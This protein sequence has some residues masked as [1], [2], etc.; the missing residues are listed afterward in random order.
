MLC[1]ACKLKTSAIG[2]ALKIRGSDE[3]LSQSGA[4]NNGA[5]M[6][7]QPH[8]AT[9]NNNDAK[10]RYWETLCS[11]PLSGLVVTDGEYQVAADGR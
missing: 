1:R 8:H 4:V 7:P 6:S 10:K 2:K 3:L 9:D 5:S 11:F